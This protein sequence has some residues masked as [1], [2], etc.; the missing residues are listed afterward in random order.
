MTVKVK[1]CGLTTAQ[2]V[3]AAVTAGASCIG[4]VFFDKSP[5]N[6]SPQKAK[7]LASLIPENIIKCGVVVN[8]ADDELDH[9]LSH[10]PLD[11][12]QLHGDESPA[13]TQE[14]R[15]RFKLPVTKAI[16]VSG[17]DD[18]TRAKTYE[19]TADMLLF[20]ARPPPALKGALPG[21]NG[22]AFDWHLIR[23]ANIKL[24]WILSGGLDEDNLAQAIATS[25]AKMIDV[26]SGI[27]DSPGEKN[28]DKITAFLRRTR[29][30]NETG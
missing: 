4:F 14:I 6:I 30:L 28:I 22:L 12:V 9:I 18:I 24:P 15:T 5:R 13:R 25:G 29:M 16:A 2:T 7:N 21:G 19:S 3:T 8:P 27:E 10:I 1:I 20:D 23:G 17:P 11:L 26:S